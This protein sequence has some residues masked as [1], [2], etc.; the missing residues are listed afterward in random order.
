MMWLVDLTR[1]FSGSERT[2]VDRVETL[3]GYPGDASV[4][5]LALTGQVGALGNVRQ[6]VRSIDRVSTDEDGILRE[7]MHIVNEN[8]QQ[9]GPDDA[10]I[11]RTFR[12]KLM[13]AALA[14]AL[15]D[16]RLIVER[17][18]THEQAGTE[19]PRNFI[20]LEEALRHLTQAVGAA[21]VEVNQ[22]S[23]RQELERVSPRWA[24]KSEPAAQTPGLISMLV[25][26]G[27]KRQLI[28]EETVPDRPGRPNFVPGPQAGTFRPPSFPAPHAAGV[29]AADTTITLSTKYIESLRSASMGPFQE[30]RWDI[31]DAVEAH[32]HEELSAREL[33]RVAVAEVRAEKDALLSRRKPFPWSRVR[34][35]LVRLASRAGV[36]LHDKDVVWHSLNDS[37]IAVNG[38]V[39][40]W[41]LVLDAELF[42]ELLRA[43]L[44]INQFSVD[45]LAGALY[46][47]RDDVQLDRAM[48]LMNYV[49]RAGVACEDP[50]KQ[51]NFVLKELVA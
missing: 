23:L 26:E 27:I 49:V 28:R 16:S 21:A 41:R 25:S 51:G 19:W 12:P 13:N 32:L 29:G 45:E 37:G 50:D 4:T 3:D 7:C 47:K 40:E 38:L 46:N 39:P 15:A 48:D 9:A 44:E 18:P 17:M 20:P 5:L 1:A 42:K 36:F 14:L 24:K 30:V 35:F 10:V 11:L 33:L 43:G 6:T 2:V 8:L 22:T 34:V 31:Y